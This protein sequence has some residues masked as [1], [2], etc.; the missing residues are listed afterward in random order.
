MKKKISDELSLTRSVTE[1]TIRGNSI[2]RIRP[3]GPIFEH[4]FKKGLRETKEIK[5]W[6][7]G[8]CLGH[9]SYQCSHQKR[10]V[11]ATYD[12]WPLTM[13]LLA[14]SPQRGFVYQNKSQ[15]VSSAASLFAMQHG[16]QFEWVR[17][18]FDV[19]FSESVWERMGAYALPDAQAGEQF[20]TNIFVHF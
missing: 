12:R 5:L 19:F 16:G 6:K 4:I 18:K 20:S 10:N 2:R 17:Q 8:V 14:P 11:K 3:C 1:N 7:D 13:G 15:Y 9:T